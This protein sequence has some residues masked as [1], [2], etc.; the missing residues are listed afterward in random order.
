MR[1][2][3]SS[4]NTVC[5]VCCVSCPETRWS[6][7]K[8]VF[9]VDI[10]A[11]IA[12]QYAGVVNKIEDA[13]V[14]IIRVNTPYERRQ[15]PLEPLMHQGALNFKGK[16]LRRIRQIMKAKPTVVCVYIERAV[17]ISEIAEEAA[18]LLAT[19]GSSDSALLD[20]LFGNFKPI[21]KL[22]IELPSSMEAVRNQ[23]EDLPYDSEDP[24]FKF[25]FG[26]TY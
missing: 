24:L 10:N 22:P 11:G 2:A 9:V 17:V 20:V 5:R 16:A 4:P 13:D 15:G 25:G 18:A 26:L 19:F 6:S 12:S 23:K 14:A 3:R 7:N 1:Q 8:K 21:G